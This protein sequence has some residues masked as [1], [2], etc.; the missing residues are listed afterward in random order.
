MRATKTSFRV[1]G[2][3]ALLGLLSSPRE[4]GAV[5][6]DELKAAIVL[7]IMLFVEWPAEAI[8][9]AGSPWVLCVNPRGAL[10]PAL[11]HLDG[12]EVRGGRVLVRNVEPGRITPP[13]HALVV[14]GQDGVQAARPEREGMLPNML[15]ISDD[16]VLP[17]PAAVVVLRRLG[18]RIAFDVNLQAARPARLQL[19]AKL[20]RLAKVVKE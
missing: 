8:P 2:L 12:R 3:L 13:C 5:E 14:E 7:N 1:A 18:S 20:L 15:V 16:V 19:S 4:A 11:R 9:P 10:A 17:S 6:E